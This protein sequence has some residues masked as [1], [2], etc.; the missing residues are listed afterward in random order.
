MVS[1]V[2]PNIGT[3]FGGTLVTITGTSFTPTATVHFGATPANSV[4]V[5]STTITAT[6][7]PAS[8]GPVNVTVTT[9]GGTSATG[10]RATRSYS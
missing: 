6:S 9:P 7:P 10:P 8:A 3:S 1:T 4:T 5:N 2:A